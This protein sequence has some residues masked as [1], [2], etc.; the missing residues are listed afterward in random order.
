MG[1]IIRCKVT[2]SDGKSA[3][4][5]R[6]AGFSVSELERK[7]AVRLGPGETCKVEQVV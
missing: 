2:I 1:G 4:E 7:W 6:Y 5:L 3:H